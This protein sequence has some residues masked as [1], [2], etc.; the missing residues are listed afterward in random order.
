MSLTPNA[1]TVLLL[2]YVLLLHLLLGY[3]H[4]LMIKSNFS[5]IHYPGDP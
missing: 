3:A 5:I 1:F 2:Q 4:D